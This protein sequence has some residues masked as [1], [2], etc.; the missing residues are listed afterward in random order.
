M[1]IDMRDLNTDHVTIYKAWLRRT[2]AVYAG[3]IMLG[4]AT[5]AVFALTEEPTAATYLA[6]AL[7][8]SAP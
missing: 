4:A 1:R 8:L 2:L 7:S 5:I 3:I 6:S